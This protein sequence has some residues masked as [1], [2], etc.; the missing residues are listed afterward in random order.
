MY[1]YLYQAYSWTQN[2][3]ECLSYNLK[4]IFVD[5]FT[6]QHSFFSPQ[7]K[8]LNQPRPREYTFSVDFR[9]SNDLFCVKVDIDGNQI[10]TKT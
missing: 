4:K 6:F 10:G 9:I 7:V 1:H 8:I 5:I 2:I 3:V